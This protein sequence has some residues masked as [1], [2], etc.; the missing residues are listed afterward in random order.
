MNQRLDN[1]SILTTEWYFSYFLSVVILVNND[2]WIY[3]L[4]VI[5]TRYR[6]SLN[7]FHDFNKNP[8]L[9]IRC[10]KAKLLYQKLRSQ[11]CTFVVDAIRTNNLYNV[12]MAIN[13][14]VAALQEQIGTI[15]ELA[16][17]AL[18]LNI[19]MLLTS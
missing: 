9:D 16:A 1:I 2:Y 15:M 11:G 8:E 18:V 6:H 10:E 17:E 19:D 14:V 5:D 4:D 13:T 12:N 7:Y 3:Q